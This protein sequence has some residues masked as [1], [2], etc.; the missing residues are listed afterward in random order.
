MTEVRVEVMAAPTIKLLPDKRLKLNR[1][2]VFDLGQF[3]TDIDQPDLN[4][5]TWTWSLAEESD[6]DDP[7]E[8][9][10]NKNLVTPRGKKETENSAIR[11]IARDRDGNKTEANMKLTVLPMQMGQLF[12][13]S[14][15]SIHCGWNAGPTSSRNIQFG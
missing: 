14:I 3:V 5:L 15:I 2:E 4:G 9:S 6:S 10:I 12:R 8:V 7:V 11:F 13:F 1:E